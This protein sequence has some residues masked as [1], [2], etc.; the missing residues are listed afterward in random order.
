M[1]IFLL[2]N[3]AGMVYRT[4]EPPKGKIKPVRVLLGQES[5]KIIFRTNGR[6]TI[7]DINNLVIKRGYDS[8]A[9]NALSVLRRIRIS[10]DNDFIEYKGNK[11]RGDLYLLPENGNIVSVINVVPLE[12]YL[13][14]VVPSEMPPSFPDEALKAQAVCA[15][16]YAVREMLKSKDRN[17]DVTANTSSQ[18]YG[19]LDK[20]HKKTTDAVLMT[21]GV[22]A[23]YD[24]EPIESFFHSNSG[25][26]TEA[27][28]NLWGS[29]LP[30][31]KT[32]RSS[33]CKAGKNYSWRLVL[34]G[35]EVDSKFARYGLG[36]IQNIQVLGRTSSDRVDLLEVVGS[37]K[38]MKIKGKEFRELMG[39]STI[40]S[41]RFG[42]KK[43]INGFFVKGLGFGHGIG[44]SQWGSYGMARDN[45]KYKKILKQYFR[46]IDLARIDG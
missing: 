34:P 42:I 33:Y 22:L 10:T 20:E 29:K 25:G 5:G 44:L 14:S 2:G 43:D 15:R 35:A 8:V 6:Y 38:R 41:L 11:Y 40:K 30:Y 37:N 32:T 19:G 36:K 21:K 28:E 9:I 17:Y 45:Y 7:H 12:Q 13:L 39:A 31:L 27:P 18:V 1:V 23:V 26:K 16:T 3:C 24:G 46:G 4:W